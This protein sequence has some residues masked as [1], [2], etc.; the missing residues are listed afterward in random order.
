[1]RRLV[2]RQAADFNR[3]GFV[4]VD[5]LFHP[6]EVEAFRK[7]VKR[8]I[9]HFLSRT[10]NSSLEALKEVQSDEAL[11][12]GII[13]LAEFDRPAFDAVYDTIWQMP[14]F[15]RLVSKPV[16]QRIAN[17]LMSRGSAAPV[18]SFINRCRITLPGDAR[19]QTGWH[20]EIFQTV[21]QSNFVQIWAPM[22]H[23]ATIDMGPVILCTGSHNKLMPKPE[24]RENTNGVSKVMFDSTIA[25]R[26][27]QIPM[28]LRLGQAVFFSGTLLHGSRPNL[29]AKVRYAMVGLFHDV[30]DPHFLP[31]KWKF[32]FRGCT[33]RDWFDSLPDN[34]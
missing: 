22:I 15:L 9:Q 6:G 24:W 25:D 33:P 20:R 5:G 29:S 10:K 11:D 27:D 21:P 4:V 17:Q 3:D 34:N 13:R 1:M 26:F 18:Y 7:A 30:E 23:D 12:L 19:S 8:V 28:T 31:P 32:S 16:I 14:E 2:V